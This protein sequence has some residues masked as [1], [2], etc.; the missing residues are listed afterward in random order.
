MKLFVFIYTKKMSSSFSVFYVEERNIFIKKHRNKRLKLSFIN[1]RKSCYNFIFI[2]NH[3]CLDTGTHRPQPEG[4]AVL[5]LNFLEDRLPK[6]E[7][8]RT[9]GRT[10]RE[11]HLSPL[12]QQSSLEAEHFQKMGNLGTAIK[13]RFCLEVE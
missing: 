13:G 4:H 6:E 7:I 11:A 1:Q 9:L 10:I 5:K 2:P 8:A 3:L 12:N